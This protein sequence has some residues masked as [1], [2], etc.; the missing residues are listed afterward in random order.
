MLAMSTFRY[1]AISKE[2]QILA[3]CKSSVP[4]LHING[5]KKL[6][7]AGSTYSTSEV[8]ENVYVMHIVAMTMSA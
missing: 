6:T 1:V 5:G 2:T 7:R 3:S 4:R 8:S